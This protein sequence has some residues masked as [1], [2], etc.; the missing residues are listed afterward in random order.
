MERGILM[1][2]WTNYQVLVGIA[3]TVLIILNNVFS[4]QIA[5]FFSFVA[6]FIQPSILVIFFTVLLIIWGFS[7][8]LLLE[9]KKGKPLFVHKIWRIM[10]A[11]IGVLFIVSS[12]ISVILGV[13][14]LS[15]VPTEMHWLLD[16]G[17]IYFLI[18]FYM[19]ILS[20]ILRYGKAD[21]SKGTIITSANAAVVTLLVVLFLLP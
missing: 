3:F 1:S 2:K 9:E 8:I 17:V 6:R 5:I 13:T 18:L 15:T 7:I 10:P 4:T 11:I 16:I 19:L 20:I 12:I 14:V 21:T